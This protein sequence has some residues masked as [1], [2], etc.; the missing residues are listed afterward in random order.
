MSA[1]TPI[2]VFG[3]NLLGI[4][5]AGAALHAANRYGARRG[6][7]VGRT[8]DAYA[9]PTKTKPTRGNGDACS[10]SAIG[11]YVANFLDYAR[12]HPELTFMVAAIGCGL[13]GFTPAQIG[14]L[15][16]GSPD[17]VKLPEVFH[18]HALGKIMRER[19][20]FPATNNGRAFE[21]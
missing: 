16:R 4:H 2:F 18:V 13:A 8:G 9:I 12:A 7:G 10:L 19:I 6:V 20:S 5:G 17:N 11:D 3:S 15:F 1:S 21:R 14:P